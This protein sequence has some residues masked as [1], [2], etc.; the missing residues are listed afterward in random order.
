MAALKPNTL[1]DI[2]HTVLWPIVLLTGMRVRKLRPDVDL[3]EDA[4]LPQS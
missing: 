3:L 2:I 4:R 1:A